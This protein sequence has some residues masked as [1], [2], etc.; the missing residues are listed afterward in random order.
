[1]QTDDTKGFDNAHL[2]A[3]WAA[4]RHYLF[5]DL[6]SLADTGRD[7]D[8]WPAGKTDSHSERKRFLARARG[9]L[10]RSLGRAEHD[11]P[12]RELEHAFQQQI[13]FIAW[14]PEVPARLLSWL[15]Q[16]GDARLKRRI[17][18]VIDH[19]ATRLARILDRARQQGLVRADI[20]PRSEAMRLVGLIQGLALG[21]GDRRWE[22]LLDEASGTF[23]C[24]R[25]GL[26]GTAE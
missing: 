21:A 1:M 22:M 18:A 26:I 3:W 5:A 6:D 20:D 12:L 9:R 14:H 16:D 23:A 2:Q 17:R 4:T 7:E 13:A 15:R 11:D 8:P 24:F 10:L 19:Y 25:T